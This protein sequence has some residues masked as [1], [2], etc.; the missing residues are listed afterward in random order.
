MGRAPHGLLR[1]VQPGRCPWGGVLEF[2]G[3][4]GSARFAGAGPHRDAPALIALKEQGGKLGE[5]LSERSERGF[6]APSAARGKGT[7]TEPGPHVSA[8]SAMSLRVPSLRSVK[9][10]LF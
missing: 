8:R 1:T 6:L 9:R 4:K 5:E 3:P 7:S 2:I 10:K